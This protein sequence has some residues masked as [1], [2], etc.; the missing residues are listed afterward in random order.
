MVRSV[1]VALV[2]LLVATPVHV[3]PRLLDLRYAPPL[4]FFLPDLLPA[5]PLRHVVPFSYYSSHSSDYS[6]HLLLVLR[7][8]LLTD[9]VVGDDLVAAD[10]IHIVNLRLLLLDYS[11]LVVGK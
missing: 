4:R 2:T 8:P 5:A 6:L 7:L 10:R 9:V 11:Y 1:I 3:Y